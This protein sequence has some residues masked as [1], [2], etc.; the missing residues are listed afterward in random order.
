MVWVALAVSSRIGNASRTIKS[1]A[2]D[3]ECAAEKQCLQGKK[4]LI[5]NG[6]RRSSLSLIRQI[7]LG[8][9]LIDFRPDFKLGCAYLEWLMLCVIAQRSRKGS[10]KGSSACDSTVHS[11]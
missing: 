2:P 3:S 11:D 1:V 9:G 10:N 7:R 5:S 8:D 6:G 4:K